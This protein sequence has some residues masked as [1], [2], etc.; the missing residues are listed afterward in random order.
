[1]AYPKEIEE[2]VKLIPK[3]H[4][5]NIEKIVKFYYELGA[6]DVQNLIKGVVDIPPGKINEYGIWHDN[7]IDGG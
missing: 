2:M 7:D 3:E 5:K 4:H 6:G 1:M